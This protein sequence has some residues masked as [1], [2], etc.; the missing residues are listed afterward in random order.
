MT[1]TVT[2][3]SVPEAGASFETVELERRDLRS[4]DVRIDIAYAGIC[5]SDIHT[6]RGEWGERPFPITPGHEIIGTV[7][8]VGSAVS[9]V[10]IGDTVGVGCFV[11]SCGECAACKDGEEQFC[12]R[13]VV[14]TYA[15]PDYHGEVTQGGYSQGVVV[16]DHFVLTIP[17]GVDLAA[18][19]PLLCAGITTYS[20]LKAH[21]V[22]P[23]S[24]VAVVGMGGLGHV[25]VKIA[26]ALGAEVTVLSRTTS[27]E[28]DGRSFGADDYRATKD[29]NAFEE[30]ASSFDFILN[31]VGA[32]LDVDAYLGLLGRGGTLVNVGAPSAPQK[33]GIFSLLTNRRNYAGSMVGGIPETQEMLDF[34]AEHGITATIELIDAGD[35]DAYYDKVVDGDVRYRAVIDAKTLRA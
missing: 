13:G 34:C 32:D 21:G 31:T 12:E 30:L 28:E 27:K 24:K 25:A 35:V 20:P 10:K 15:T 8:E 7:A 23:G 33:F 18:T 2:A 29:G 17:D 5:H 19:T 16:R 26:K 1:T 14:Q 22:G 11:D 3:L 4:D 9:R 6:V